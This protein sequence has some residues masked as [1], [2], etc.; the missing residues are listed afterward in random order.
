MKPALTTLILVTLAAG[1]SGAATYEIA[2]DGSGDFATIQDALDHAAHGDSIVLRDGTFSWPGN[3]GIDFLGKAVSVL[4]AS[5]DPSACVVDCLDLELSGFIFQSGETNASLIKGIGITHGWPN[6]GGG[7]YCHGSS[8]TIENCIISLNEANYGGGLYCYGGSPIVKDCVFSQNTGHYGGGI[9]CENGTQL[10]ITNCRFLD[11]HAY[12]TGG[13][14]DFGLETV[15]H[16][17]G[18]LFVGNYGDRG[19]AFNVGGLGNVSI[20]SC[21]IHDNGATSLGAGGFYIGGGSHVVCANTI[22]V[23]SIS[24]PAIRCR[25]GST[26]TL[27]CCDLFGNI[28]RFNFRIAVF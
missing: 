14:V 26:A 7:I 6:A 24:S 19:G 25:D 13:G 27:T 23:N 18:C 4:S 5:N 17:S 9:L 10:T 3:M 2:P 15:G 21:T 16:V 11:N 8:P 28:F 12:V 20:S 1:L 22:I